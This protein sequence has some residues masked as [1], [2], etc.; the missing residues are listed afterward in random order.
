MTDFNSTACL[1][2]CGP[3]QILNLEMPVNDA[4]Q[5]SILDKYGDA[6][7]TSMLKYSYSVDGVC[8]SC[9]MSLEE[10]IESTLNTIS[11]YFLRIKVPG[12]IIT[13]KNGDEEITDYTTSLDSS[14][15]LESSC[16][17]QSPNLY[18]PYANIDGAIQLQQALSDSVACMVGI[19]IYYFKVEGVKGAADITFKEYALKSVKSVKQ[20]KL[21]IQDGQMPSSK[22]EFADIGL[23]WQTDWETEVSKSMFATAFG[24]TAQ[25]TEGDLI[26][27]PMQKRMWMVNEA[28]DEKNG[29]LMWQSTTWKVALVKY[30]ID[31]SLNLNEHDDFVEELVKNKY[32]DLFGN[33]EELD[34]GTNSAPL[35]QARP[36]NLY[37]VFKSD[38]TRKEM[39]CN[40]I[41]F[42]NTSLYHKGTLVMDNCYT[43]IPAANQPMQIIYQHPYCG[44]E[45]S[46]SFIIRVTPNNEYEC[47]LI[48]FGHLS[49]NIHQTKNEATL[50]FN[51]ID[52][53]KLTLQAGEWY[54][55]TVRFSKSLRTFDMTASINKHPEN[56]PLYQ[57]SNWHYF[58]DVDNC[59]Q[60]T[61]RWNEELQISHKK[62]VS[63]YGFYGEISNV[64]MMDVYD[65][66]LSEL[67]MQYPT[68]QRLIINDTA[69]PLYG[70]LG[71]TPK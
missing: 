16:E 45:C 23:D 53:C 32:E 58:F 38:S 29:S 65:D 10:L 6:Y 3:V 22:P 47:K 63:L 43:F 5:V 62:D 40:T 56:I 67:M 42:Q 60:T 7:N 39:T 27:I 18:N 61:A 21:I 34:S 2:V 17:K 11:D 12:E 37:S 33:D 51:V 44:S 48:E 35:T 8:W 20:I 70:L 25:P 66:K 54:F 15:N 55:V 14:F 19:P 26:Y 4:S 71:T 69:R 50:T 9:Y 1:G 13:V 24:P 30:Q 41:D 49:L 57:L 28:Y 64:K 36:A 59:Q 31:G 46:I 52:K 68:H